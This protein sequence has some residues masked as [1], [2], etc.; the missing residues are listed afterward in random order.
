MSRKELLTLY[1]QADYLFIHLNDY[2]AFKKV[3]PSKIFELGAYDKPIIAGV[4]GYASDF[5]SENISNKIL[6]APGDVD[7]FVSQLRSFKYKN[8]WR[9]AFLN[10]FKRSSINKDLAKSIISYL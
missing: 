3:L 8:E 2:N 1:D 10:N 5:I 4:G 9:T 7:S 6:F